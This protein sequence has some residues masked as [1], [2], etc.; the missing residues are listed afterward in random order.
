MSHH[1]ANPS[2]FTPGPIIVH[3][4][5]D[6]VVALGDDHEWTDNPLANFYGE[7][8][9]GNARL[10]AAAPTLCAALSVLQKH[11]HDRHCDPHPMGQSEL[12]KIAS[13]AL[14]L[15]EGGQ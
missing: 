15:V 12:C 2:A 4:G 5:E 14:A 13:D 6:Y 7:Q 11:V 10:F 1:E 9:E 8:A 3:A